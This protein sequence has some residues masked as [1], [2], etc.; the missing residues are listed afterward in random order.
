MFKSKKEQTKHWMDYAEKHLVGKTI[1]AV[2]WMTEKEAVHL[3]WQYSRPIVIEFMDG[4][5]IFPSR[6]DEGN[7]GGALFGQSGDESLT[8]PVNGV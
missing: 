2:G 3:G 1:K 4:T 7:D 5:M 6:D 8:F